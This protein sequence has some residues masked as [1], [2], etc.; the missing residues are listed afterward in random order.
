MGRLLMAHRRLL[1]LTAL[2]TCLA[3]SVGTLTVSAQTASPQ[4]STGHQAFDDALY[5]NLK[6][7]W[8]RAPIP[9]VTG[10]PDF[11]PTKPSGRGQ[12]APL[13]PEYQAIFEANLADQA[14]G[15]FGT[16]VGWHC[17]AW[18]LP[19][20]MNVYQP[21]EIVVL[22][23]TT[24]ILTSD[25]HLSQRRIYTDGRDWPETIEPEFQGG[26]SVGKWLDEDGDGRYDTLEV[27]TRGFKGP[28][29]FGSSGIPLHADNQ[30]I[31]KE[32]IYLDKTNP[33]IL[34]NE[35]TVIDHALTR[36]WTATKSYRRTSAAKTVWTEYVCAV[37]QSHVRIGKENYYMSGDGYL[38]PAKKDQAPP[39]LRYF[40]RTKD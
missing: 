21:M 14:A 5:P 26:Y 17:G 27:E 36:P 8:N 34:H 18:G 9:G 32:R 3:A 6:G 23:D 30:T 16:T 37:D 35:M 13:T 31:V 40:N 28:R 19:A 24:Y 29:V 12:Q 15:G 1:L 20:M 10:Q 2:M 22:P 7:Q 4:L 25:T 33:D 11:D 38:M 39:D